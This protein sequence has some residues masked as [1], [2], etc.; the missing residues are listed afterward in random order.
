MVFFF[1]DI[2]FH[3]DHDVI[4]VEVFEDLGVDGFDFKPRDLLGGGVDV[5]DV[6]DLELNLV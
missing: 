3:F 5:E 6:G 2:H 4:L 1:E